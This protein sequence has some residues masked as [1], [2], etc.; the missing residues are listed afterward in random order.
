VARPEDPAAAAARARPYRSRDR[1]ARAAARAR[2]RHAARRFGFAG[3]IASA[4]ECQA[5]G[6]VF[7]PVIFGW[8]VHAYPFEQDPAK[9][10]AH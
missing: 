7:H 8:M 9:I 2:R 5:S 10:W 3:S 1:S 4:A 6:G